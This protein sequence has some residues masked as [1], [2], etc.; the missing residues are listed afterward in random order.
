[1][2]SANGLLL[3]N[4]YVNEFT[5]LIDGSKSPRTFTGTKTKQIYGSELP[6]DNSVPDHFALDNF[7]GQ[8]FATINSRSGNYDISWR[9]LTD[10]DI[11]VL[12]DI[13][14]QIV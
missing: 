5:R 2:F 7:I 11:A 12:Q 14:W 10:L 8:P 1:M 3:D 4:Y 6:L 9:D 13:G